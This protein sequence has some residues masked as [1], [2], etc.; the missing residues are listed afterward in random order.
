[1]KGKHM[2]I[3]MWIICLAVI[4]MVVPAYSQTDDEALNHVVIVLDGSGSMDDL[5]SP[6]PIKKMDAAKDALTRV[7]ETI[8]PETQVGLLVFSTSNLTEDWVYPLG[9][10]DKERLKQAILLPLPG[11]QTPLGSYIKK[12][13]DRLLEERARR[14]GYGTYKLLIVTDGEAQDQD[15]V[16]TYTPDVISRGITMDV[17]GVA[18]SSDHTLATRVHSYKRADDPDALAQALIEVFAEVGGAGKDLESEE[19]FKELSSIPD[20]M[21][22]A[23]IKALAGSGNQPIGETKKDNLDRPLL[24]QTANSPSSP[25]EPTPLPETGTTLKDVLFGLAILAFIALVIL[26]RV[27]FQSNKKREKK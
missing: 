21:A 14:F 10:L 23:M 12:A 24:D 25:T 9:P 7:I 3:R 5:M 18:M 17:I 11:G 19:V 6:T 1:M 26:M 20:D 13:A 22:K 15:R 8:D 4:G 2:N 27:K 16:S